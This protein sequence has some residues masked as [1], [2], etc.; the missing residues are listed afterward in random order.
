MKRLRLAV[1]GLH[2]GKVLIEEEIITGLGV[3]FFELVA[4]CDQRES[5]LREC[6]ES[7]GVSGYGSIEEMLATEALDLVALMTGP[8][9]RAELM[10]SI[11]DRGMAVVTTKP[12]ENSAREAERILKKAEKLGIP[13]FIN[14]PEPVPFED[15]Q[16]M[17]TWREQYHMGKLVGYHACTWAAYREQADG[18]WY[19][20]PLLCPA[21]PLFRLG[22]Y[23]INNLGWFTEEVESILLMQSRIF[24]E[25]PTADNAQMSIY[26]RDGCLGSIY[27]S[28]CI[29][30]TEPYKDSLELRFENGVMR[31]TICTDDDRVGNRIAI[32]LVTGSE[33]RT[34]RL[35]QDMP[36][37]GRGYRWE[38]IY[39]ILTDKPGAGI[40]VSTEQIVRGVRLLEMIREEANKVS[41]PSFER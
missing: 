21:A 37:Y 26:H 22:I 9:G 36:R 29:H 34:L 27:A 19:D 15:I 8:G 17:L 7:Y 14:S 18:S 31:R 24:T 25:R 23:S 2:F 11:L 20:N 12:F 30:D 10:D 16:Q 3:S 35:S 13:I 33:G 1:V 32:S 39:R 41:N 38:A 5:V 40:L 28:F 6:A 4:V